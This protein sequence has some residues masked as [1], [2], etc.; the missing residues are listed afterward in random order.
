MTVMPERIW[1][2]MDKGMFGSTGR[3][4]TQGT[5]NP[6]DRTEYI[7]AD[8][9]APHSQNGEHSSPQ[10][11]DKMLDSAIEAYGH[12]LPEDGNFS[13][14]MHAALTAALASTPGD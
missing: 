11:T 10:I 4:V 14:A 13:D 5:E 8:L 3:W 2:S 9:V 12:V 1:A 6:F 7:R